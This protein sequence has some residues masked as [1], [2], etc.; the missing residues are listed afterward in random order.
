MQEF[1]TITVSYPTVVFT[2]LLGVA[3]VYWLL[4]MLG[5]LG[6]DVMDFDLDGA[7]EG[8]AEGVVE[9]AAEGLA[10]G[11]AEGGM[12]GL[13]GVVHHG[14]LAS[15]LVGAF[16]L[17]SAPVTLVVSLIVFWGW[18]LSHLGVSYVLPHVGFVEGWFGA[19]I[20]GLT[21][22][23]GAIPLTALIV[24]PLGK[25][26]QVEAQ[27]SRKHLVGKIVVIDTGRVDTA[28][29]SARAD[30]GGPGLVVQVRCDTENRLTRG[31][32]ALVVAYDAAREAYEVTPVDDILP[33]AAV[34]ETRE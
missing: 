19:T 34:D 12:E 17:R 31:S 7:A 3:V 30:D 20:V 2:A 29:G 4:V 1:L 21:A 22:L 13:H 16:N 26:L 25:V 8:G 14:G 24:R 15:V 11:A 18:I 32:R 23:A 33:S 6:I 27:T 10:E 5:A 9:G 28:F